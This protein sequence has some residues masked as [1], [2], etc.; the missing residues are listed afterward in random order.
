MSSSSVLAPRARTA[1]LLAR[2]GLD[3]L[4]VDHGG[5]FGSDTVSTH[6]LMRAGVLQLRR[7]GVLD[8]IVDAGT[9]PVR[10]TSFHYADGTLEM[11]LKPAAGVD[12]LYA[13]RRT[14][15]D[16][17]LVDAARDAGATVR[18]GTTVNTLLQDRDDQVAGISGRDRERQEFSARAA[19]TIG[20]D[21]LHSF[22]ARQVDAP[23]ERVGRH[24]SACVY[25]YW[26]D[27]DVDGYEWF[28]RAGTMIGLIPTNDDEVCVCVCAPLDRLPRDGLRRADRRG[29]TGGRRAI[30]DCGQT[31][32]AAA[33]PRC[34]RI[35]APGDRAG[36][37]P[38]RRCRLLQGPTE[39]ARH[40][41]RTPPTPSS[42]HVGSST[43]RSRSISANAIGCRPASSRSSTSWPGSLGTPTGSAIY[44]SR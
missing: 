16:R 41:R 26:A 7:W 9:T 22:V 34:T 3:V 14:V 33:L 19:L 12:A 13:P 6:A 32:P 44:C 1:M 36:M 20:A 30:D 39:R 27:L 11:S 15:L 23:F 28:W 42:S 8:A 40:H 31:E 38:R 29:R 37:G 43:A 21:G 17:L 24:A 18:F 25:A 10:R 5:I 4:V 35:R 2:R